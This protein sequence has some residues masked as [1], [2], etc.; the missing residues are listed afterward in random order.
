MIEAEL[1]RQS[2][3][4]IAGPRYISAHNAI[5]HLDRQRRFSNTAVAQDDELVLRL[6]HDI[7][8]PADDVDMIAFIRCST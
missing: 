4:T 8:T 7:I 5:T 6:D 2:Q 3:S 1:S